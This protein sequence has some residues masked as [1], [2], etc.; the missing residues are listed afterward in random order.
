MLDV[1]PP[2]RRKLPLGGLIALAIVPAAAEP[3]AK[4][5]HALDLGV[6]DR[7]DVDVR[8]G[9]VALEHPVLVLVGLADAQDLAD[10]FQRRLVSG[11]VRGIGDC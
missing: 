2:S 10:A 11:L 3:V 6:T 7:E 4:R 5:D 8:R 9:V 1:T